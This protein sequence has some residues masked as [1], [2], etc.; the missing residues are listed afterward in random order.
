MRLNKIEIINF[1]SYKGKHTIEIRDR[2]TTIIGPNGSGKSNILDAISFGLN[3]S[4]NN[5]RIKQLKN[6][7][8]EGEKECK[9]RIFIDNL[10]FE[11]QLLLKNEDI[12]SKYIFN[13]TKISQTSFN[14]ELQ[15]INIYARIPNF[16]IYQGDIIKGNV[17]L[18]KVIENVSGSCNFKQDYEILEKE[19]LEE[20]KKLSIIYEKKKNAFENL[21]K[22]KKSAEAEIIFHNLVEE[23]ELLEKL[24]LKKEIDQKTKEINKFKEEVKKNEEFLNFNSLYS[25][26][27]F[28]FCYEKLNTARTKTSSLQKEYFEL[29]SEISY[30]RNKIKMKENEFYNCNEKKELE[31]KLYNYEIEL[32]KIKIPDLDKIKNEIEVKQKEFD[33][34]VFEIEN[35]LN[36][37]TLQNFEKINKK[38][39]I[40]M[41]INNL[42]KIKNRNNLILKE[43]EAKKLKIDS[44]KKEIYVL[45]SKVGEKMTNYD[46]IILDEQKFNNQLNE[47]IQKILISKSKKQDITRQAFVKNCID[48]LKTMFSGVYGSVMDVIKP[49]QARYEI[50]LGILISKYENAVIVDNEKTAYDCLKYLKES[51]SCRLTFLPLNRISCD[52][53]SCVE[54]DNTLLAKK[55]V[56]YDQKYQNIIDYVFKDSIIVE[57]VDLAKNLAFKNRYPGTICTING[58]VFHSNGLI[59]GG[60]NDVKNKF[61]ENEIDLLLKRRKA[62]LQD[63]KIIN[64]RK[65]AFSDVKIIKEKIE[66]LNLRKNSINFLELEIFDENSLILLQEELKNLN[67]QKFEEEKTK[68]KEELKRRENEIFYTTLKKIGISNILEYKEMLKQEFKSEELKMKIN[69]LKERI[70]LINDSKQESVD[71]EKITKDLKIKEEKLSEIYEKLEISRSSLKS[72]NNEFKSI[73]DERVKILNIISKNKVNI[74]RLEEELNDLK[75]CASIEF[76]G[77]DSLVE[78]I[79]N[80]TIKNDGTKYQNYD[81]NSLISE[82]DGVNGKISAAAPDLNYLADDSIQRKYSAINLEY[83]NTKSKVLGIKKKFLDVKNA[84]FECF[85]DCFTKISKEIAIIYRALSYPSDYES[86]VNNLAYI[87]YEGDVFVNNLKYYLMPP[88]KRFTEFSE[89]SGGEKSLALLCFIFALSKY[90]SPP[91][92]IFDEVDSALDKINV[93]RLATFIK[94]SE[95]Q[96]LIIS[97][98]HQFFKN[99]E[100][101]VGVYKCPFDLKSK[102]LTYKLN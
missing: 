62:I 4:N 36:K 31:E 47:V 49:T 71:S 83:E 102:I 18:L 80:V 40:L 61:E 55:C 67:L 85:N 28:N 26:Y 88:M 39:E 50:P 59:T 94:E 54:F 63:L 77:D 34:N 2:F 87:A 60:N 38:E 14:E 3:V 100:S 82:L 75:N 1:K 51:R 30:L 43:N 15:K 37:I 69:N 13:A 17:D 24:I 23:K 98:K 93:D 35:K 33:E 7:I 95:D 81:L 70:S 53:K 76:N 58:T 45:E 48:N 79:K 19:L 25:E 64:D 99:S 78:N 101:L 97:L 65:E 57:N 29:E 5:L 44:I 84:R 42:N 89:L 52:L 90:K 6:L 16:V 74:S 66:E 68:I 46:N 27:N 91:F 12:T 10:I 32:Q 8:S 20:N 11:R 86:E 9:V 41:K 96:F 21:K 92:Y 72:L 73:N 56:F 22:Q